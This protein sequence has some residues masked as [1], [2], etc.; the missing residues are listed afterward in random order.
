MSMSTNTTLRMEFYKFVGKV[1]NRADARTA[2][3]T[4]SAG[5]Y[6]TEHGVLRDDV[7]S[8]RLDLDKARELND[9]LR[10]RTEDAIKRFNA[11]DATSL[12]TRLLDDSSLPMDA[13]NA[14]NG[15]DTKS[16]DKDDKDTKDGTKPLKADDKDK[17][18]TPSPKKSATSDDTAATPT[19]AKELRE[20]LRK[21]LREFGATDDKGNPT[22]AA[23]DADLKGLE[24]RVYNLEEGLGYQLN[25]KGEVMLTKLTG[26]SAQSFNW[27]PAGITAALVFL[28][29]FV[30]SLTAFDMVASFSLLFSAVVGVIAGAVAGA[31]SAHKS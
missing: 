6:G 28:V 20:D 30:L 7:I 10:E 8:L 17:D 15:K 18:D 23:A 9:D 11:L 26:L 21:D 3:E 1:K 31:I 27:K 5:L 24:N 22:K 16:S 14:P 29:M 19:W 12:N 25:K 13:S 2:L 4:L